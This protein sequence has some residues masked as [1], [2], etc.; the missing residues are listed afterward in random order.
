MN[1]RVSAAE[2]DLLRRAA[3]AEHVSFSDFVRRASFAAAETTLADRRRFVVDDAAWARYLEILDAPAVA[4]PRLVR[5]FAD[6]D[7]AE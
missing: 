6:A 2:R 4:V 5:L 3:E 1:I 7:S